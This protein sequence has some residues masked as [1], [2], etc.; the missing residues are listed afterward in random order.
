MDK[1]F[2]Y[3]QAHSDPVFSPPINLAIYIQDLPQEKV[4]VK[5]LKIGVPG[6][7]SM[8]MEVFPK[9]EHYEWIIEDKVTSTKVHVKLGL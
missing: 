2:S 5:G 8:Q 3:I 6:K 9:P 7:L 1:R 4:L